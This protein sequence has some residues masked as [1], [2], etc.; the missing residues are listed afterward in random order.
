[1]SARARIRRGT[2]VVALLL[3]SAGHRLAAQEPDAFLQSVR[4]NVVH[5]RAGAAAGFGFIVGLGEGTVLIA[6]AEHT[7]DGADGAPRICFLER[8]NACAEGEV[9]YVDDPRAPGDPD[10]DLALIE[11]AY[12]DR[13]P[14]RPDVMGATPP[15]GEPA[16]FIGRNEDWFVPDAPGRILSSDAAGGDLAYTGMAV[17]A[18]VSGA[19][20]LVRTGIVGMHREST[21]GE[22]ESRG[23]LL[24]AI[25]NRVEE[26]L[27]RQW[28]LVP[29]AAC[30]ADDGARRILANRWVTVRFPWHRAA[31]AMNAMAR[32]R[33]VGALPL[34]RPLWEGIEG[35]REIVYRTGDLRSARLLQTVLSPLGRIEPR[36]GSPDGEMELI[37]P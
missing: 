23:V 29:R 6:T 25:R 20:I 15:A 36:L 26:R 17:A 33:C 13:L 18:G 14:W 21:G 7:L 19:P 3:L 37:L 11:V 5:V 28:V 10:L 27:G 30:P 24:D 22:D 8:P 34:P 31:S 1:M 35:E 2:R 12:P 9:V 4:G 32:L 16:W